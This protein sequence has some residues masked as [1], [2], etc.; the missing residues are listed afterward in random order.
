MDET[1]PVFGVP[2]RG[3]YKIPGLEMPGLAPESVSALQRGS[4][5]MGQ[6]PAQPK[7]HKGRGVGGVAQDIVGFL[8]DFLLTKLGMPAMYGPGQARKKMANA[9]EGFDQ[10]PLA[11]INRVTQVDPASGA[12]LRDQF[13]DNERLAAQ[14]AST[15]ESRAARLEL[16]QTA[17]NDKTRGRASAML[18]TMAQWD[19]DKRK[20]NYGA[21]RDQILRYSKANGLDLEGELPT[22]YDPV[23]LDAFVDASVPV[24]MQRSQRLASERADTTREQGEARLAQGDRRLSESE[25]HNR[26]G[27]GQ[28]EA[29]IGQGDRRLDQGDERFEETRSQNRVRNTQG[30]ARLAQGQ[31]N[32]EM[33]RTAQRAAE[34]RARVKAGLPPRA[35]APTATTMR[36]GATAMIAGKP[37]IRTGGRWV[38][39]PRFNR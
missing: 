8:G 30:Q 16:A 28:G 2:L 11:A 14:N 1:T 34:D 29:R 15:A 4:S 26:V 6:A 33:R 21:M 7:E 22:G 31:A 20:N 27:E 19:D 12:K 13:I 9:M 32:V 5:G 37:Y 35:A 23:A 17:Q 39:D 18:G 38:P 10:D 3:E 25:R 24:G 36:D